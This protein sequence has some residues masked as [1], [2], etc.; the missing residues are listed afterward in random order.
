MRS[1]N[2]LS[3]VMSVGI[4]MLLSGYGKKEKPE[5]PILQNEIAEQKEGLAQRGSFFFG[6]NGHPL[7]AESYLKLTPAYQADLISR[8]GM[9]TYRVDVLTQAD[10]SMSSYVLNLFNGLKKELDSKKVTILP[11][12][13][14]RTLQYTMN[15]KE[16]YDAGYRLGS[17][18]AQR[19]G[20]FFT[21]YNT[22]NEIYMDFISRAKN[23]TGISPADYD[24]NKFKIAASYLKGMGKG[25][26]DNDSDAQIIINATW[27]HFG[28]FQLLQEYGVNFDIVGWHWYDEMEREAPKAG[29][30]D[31]SVKLVE[32][33]KKPIWF[34]EIGA[35][36][37]NNDPNYEKRQDD[38]VT[39]F[40][41][42][43]RKNP[44]VHAALLHELVDM[45]EKKHVIESNYG[46]LKWHQNTS[47]AQLKRTALSNRLLT[48]RGI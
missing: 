17:G 5:Q 15:E 3:M 38:F 36:Y 14:T 13:Y 26:K 37:Q 30:S 25:I 19:Y 34:L 46:I 33:Y 32:L 2:Q 35:R 4:L 16:A 18:F 42:K 41:A 7:G 31:I 44:Q 24:Q 23:V 8:M 12:V 22:G 39:N 27:T 6:I 1:I 9:N 40:V 47:A 28:Y 10:G 48:N 45:P 43:C 29:I 20:K 11:M 21:H